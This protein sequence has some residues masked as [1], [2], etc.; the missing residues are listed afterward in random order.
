MTDRTSPLTAVTAALTDAQRQA[1]VDRFTTMNPG[2]RGATAADI[3]DTLSDVD[4]DLAVTEPFFGAHPDLIVDGAGVAARALI[5]SGQVLDAA[6]LIALLASAG[7]STAPVATSADARWQALRDYLETA[8]AEYADDGMD[9]LVVASGAV[10]AK[11]TE[12]ETRAPA[13]ETGE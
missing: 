10:L 12:L 8:K 1:I 5:W 2:W 9:A 11:M 6:N 13:G 3:L 7:L 4:S